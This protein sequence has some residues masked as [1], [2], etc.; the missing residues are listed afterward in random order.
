MERIMP[1]KEHPIYTEWQLRAGVET[2]WI[3]VG[4]PDKGPHFQ[5][6]F[7]GDMERGPVSEGDFACEPPQWVID[8]LELG[9]ASLPGFC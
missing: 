7:I 8:G 2:A 5:C 3:S 1:V 9:Q 6:D 4:D